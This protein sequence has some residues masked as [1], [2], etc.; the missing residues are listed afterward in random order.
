MMVFLSNC[1]TNNSTNE[2]MGDS[3]LQRSS[4]TRIE[5]FGCRKA[6]GAD[7]TTDDAWTT[8]RSESGGGIT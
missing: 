4:H 5:T 7:A 2:T 3:T 8:H 6:G 1:S